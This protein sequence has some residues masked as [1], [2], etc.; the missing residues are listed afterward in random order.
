MIRSLIA[1]LLLCV[2]ASAAQ[3]Q[4]FKVVV[5]AENSATITKQ[6]VSSIFLGTVKTW[7]G[8]V[9]AAPV[10]LPEKSDVRQA[11]SVAV[12]GRE[13]KAVTAHWLREIYSGR[14][15]PPIQKDT[16]AA[17]LDWVRANPGAIGYV[18]SGA[19]IPAGVKVVD[20]K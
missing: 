7:S 19:T 10:D 17:V 12:I 13:A 5:N 18:S 6:V 8:G 11:F 1:A 2:S 16:D 9:A 14:A 15:V 4:A 3:A 20:V